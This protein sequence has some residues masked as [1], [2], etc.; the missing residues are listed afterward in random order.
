MSKQ[1]IIHSSMGGDIVFES[2][3]IIEHKVNYGSAK[4]AHDR[5]REYQKVVSKNYSR[6]ELLGGYRK[7]VADAIKSL[8]NEAVESLDNIQN[9]TWSGL[10][11]VERNGLPVKLTIKVGNVIN[12]TYDTVAKK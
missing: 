2:E 3:D 6:T 11:D 9:F 4:E 12:K 1:Y 10:S 7:V 5:Q 8:A